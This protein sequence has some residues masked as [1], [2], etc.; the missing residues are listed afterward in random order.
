MLHNLKRLFRHGGIYLLGNILNRVGSFLLL[1]LYTKYLAVAEY[2]VLELL[3]ATVAVVSVLLSAG[4]S[5]TTIRFYFDYREDRDRHAVVST[6]LVLV[7]VLG[8]VG[9]LAVH[10]MRLPLSELLFDTTAY[11]GAID[12]CLAIM[13][14]EI[15]T[16]VGFAYLR[17]RELSVLYMALSFARLLLQVGLSIYLVAGH[18]MG[19]SGVL[20]ANLA[21]VALGWLV[22][23]GYTLSRCGLALRPSLVKPMLKYS[24]PMAFMGIVAAVVTNVDR[25]LLKEFLSLDAV[26]I[27]ALSMKF[28][29]LLTF[30]V[31]EPFNRAYGPFRFSI[32]DQ[33]DAEGIQRLV[34]HYLVAGATFVA[35]AIAMFMPEALY[36]MAAP[37]YQGAYRYA[38]ILLLAMVVLTVAYCFET[39]ILY[40]KKTKYLL[41][42]SLA[43]LAVK[44]TL[45][46]FLIWF[47]GIYGAALAFL[48]AAL[49]QV[50]LINR[51]SQRLYPVSYR[52]R[53]LVMFVALGAAIYLLSLGVDYHAYW[54]SIPY[55]LALTALYGV[56]LYFADAD[57]RRLFARGL[58]YL[59]PKGGHAPSH[60]N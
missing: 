37:A 43:N 29:L 41:Y 51:L 56:V 3:Y 31:S 48:V 4:L 24:L 17:A 54:L 36:F 26:G 25:F 34:V 5:H 22:V 33:P 9:A 45:N 53:S 7:V 12:L 13:V 50:S 16:E 55:K 2:G 11:A 35:L 39:G 57:I 32:I 18:G 42:V 46:V 23:V 30:L 27:Y 20:V 14:L 52:Y 40:R 58:S 47:L 60:G 44:T 28:A 38:P 59:K 21:S 8:I 49:V 10:L 1:P 6:N 19:I 15:S